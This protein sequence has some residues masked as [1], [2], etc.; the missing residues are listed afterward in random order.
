MVGEIGY[1]ARETFRILKDLK[2]DGAD[3]WHGVPTEKGGII[4]IEKAEKGIKETHSF[5]FDGVTA[6]I[7]IIMTALTV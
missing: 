3:L 4:R 6:D 7:E 2:K 1:N 5:Y